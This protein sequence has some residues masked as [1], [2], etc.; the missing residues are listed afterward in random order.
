MESTAS[1]WNDPLER[2]SG[3]ERDGTRPDEA[4]AFFDSLPAVDVE[5]VVGFWRGAGVHTGHAF[6]GVLERFGWRGKRFEDA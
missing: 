6:D 3:Y 5:S 1:P 4:L 2:L